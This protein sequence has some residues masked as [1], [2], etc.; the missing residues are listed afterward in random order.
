[1]NSEIGASGSSLFFLL[2]DKKTISASILI[3]AKKP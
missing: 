2:K 1:L 3:G